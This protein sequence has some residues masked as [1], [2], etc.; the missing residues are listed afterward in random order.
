MVKLSFVVLKQTIL[1]RGDI[2]KC[3]IYG[4]DYAVINLIKNELQ[5]DIH[6]SIENL[7]NKAKEFFPQSDFNITDISDLV[8]HLP[9]DIK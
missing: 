2:M 4:L 8:Y 7:Y 3:K 9:D 1:V 5:K 6:V